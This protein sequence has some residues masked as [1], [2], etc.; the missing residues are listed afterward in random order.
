MEMKQAFAE[1]IGVDVN[2]VEESGYD[3]CGGKVLKG[4]DEEWAVFKSE[5][6]AFDAAKQD[7]INLWE[8]D[9]GPLESISWENMNYPIEHYV[10][11]DALDNDMKES[12]YGYAVDISQE[13]GSDNY[14]NRL[15]EEMVENNLKYTGNLDDDAE[16]YSDFLCGNYESSIEWCID[17]FGK[18]ELDNILKEHPEMIDYDSLAEDVVNHD[19][20]ANILSTYDGKEVEYEGF[21][22]YRLN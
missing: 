4:N 15:Q 7:C 1:L 19:G 20:P 10:K 14:E 3:Y 13:E 22:F 5:E 17:H 12:Y 16:T 11:S 21:I 18:E 8:T 6:Q 9:I 2:D